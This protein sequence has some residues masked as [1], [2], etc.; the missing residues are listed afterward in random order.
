M[1]SIA[2]F[3]KSKS[4]KQLPPAD[5]T[6]LPNTN[7]EEET[8]LQED[9]FFNIIGSCGCKLRYRNKFNYEEFNLECPNC[10]IISRC[11][12]CVI[13]NHHT[14]KTEKGLC[15]ICLLAQVY[16]QLKKDSEQETL[17][18]EKRLKKATN[19]TYVSFEK[20]KKDEE[21]VVLVNDEPIGRYKCRSD[22]NSKNIDRKMWQ[23]DSIDLLMAMVHQQ[24]KHIKR[25]EDKFDKLMEMVEF[26]PGSSEYQEASERFVEN[27]KN[28]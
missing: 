15:D 23:E 22:I 27:V 25:L 12:R 26:A 5:N 9:T 20:L 14:L 19:K 2:S 17:E 6:T 24:S 21:I 28:I 3:M 18:K 11:T 7:L 8:N 13:C 16:S 4:N 1:K 10:H